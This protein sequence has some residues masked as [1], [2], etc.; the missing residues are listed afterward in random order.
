MSSALKDSDAAGSAVRIRF[1]LSIC[2]SSTLS[3][4]RERRDF[5]GKESEWT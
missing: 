2:G 4:Q 3:Q 1:E 5:P